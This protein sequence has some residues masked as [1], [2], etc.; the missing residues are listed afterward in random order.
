MNFVSSFAAV[1]GKLNRPTAYRPKPFARDSRIGKIKKHIDR[2]R[3]AFRDGVKLLERC[4]PRS[5][6]I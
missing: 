4:L 2:T 5:F 6:G 3:D 1:A